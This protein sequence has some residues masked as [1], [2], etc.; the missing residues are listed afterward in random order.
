MLLYKLSPI[1]KDTV[2]NDGTLLLSINGIVIKRVQETKF[3]GVIFD[4]KLKWGPLIK[5]LNSKLKC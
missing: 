5:Y 2:P 1:L 4:E 3:L